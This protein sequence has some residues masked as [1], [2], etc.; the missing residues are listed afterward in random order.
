[1]G[2]AVPDGTALDDGVPYVSTPFCDTDTDPVAGAVAFGDGAIFGAAAVA[3]C[4]PFV[5][6]W[7]DR[8][9]SAQQHREVRSD[10]RES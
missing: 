8:Q 1:V 6:P 7:N 10:S 4:V 3:L 2:V 9:T 5:Q